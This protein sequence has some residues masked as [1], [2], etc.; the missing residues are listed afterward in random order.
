MHRT[1]RLLLWPVL[2]AACSST[3]VNEGGG[4][5][6]AATGGG[7]GGGTATGGGGSGGGPTGGG[8]SGGSPTGGGGS[9]GIAGAGTGGA[10]GS[11]GVG[12]AAGNGASG[13][14][15]DGSLADAPTCDYASCAK[16]IANGS[17]CAGLFAAC[18]EA[19]ASCI[20]DVN[21]V[22]SQY[23]KGQGSGP[24]YVDAGGAVRGCLD[25]EKSKGASSPLSGK[26]FQ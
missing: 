8:G 20:T 17:A 2:I 3:S 24:C 10:S 12:G 7:G 16:A 9:G 4:S 1:W 15:T 25:S 22:V 18:A 11:G 6:G 23:C 14:A 21:C 13:G 26:C 19:G 5:G